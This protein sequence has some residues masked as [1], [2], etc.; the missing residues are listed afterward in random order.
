MD[1]QPTTKYKEWP[2]SNKTGIRW[3]SSQLWYNVVFGSV[4]KGS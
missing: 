2:D 1:R 3:W 4:K